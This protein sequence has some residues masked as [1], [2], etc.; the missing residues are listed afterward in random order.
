MITVYSTG[1]VLIK[2]PVNGKFSNDSYEGTFSVY[3]PRSY[4]LIGNLLKQFPLK[5]N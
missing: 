2:A 4:T 3:E 5:R 1:L